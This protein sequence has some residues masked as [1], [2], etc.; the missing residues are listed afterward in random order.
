VTYY[1]RE[2]IIPRLFLAFVML[3]DGRGTLVHGIMLILNLP[4]YLINHNAV[5]MN[6]IME[7]LDVHGWSGSYPGH[8]TPRK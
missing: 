7:I 5:K 2:S 3:C 8:F 6:G 1:L 4:W